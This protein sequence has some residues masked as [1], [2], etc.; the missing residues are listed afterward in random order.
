MKDSEKYDVNKAL[1]SGVF[2]GLDPAQPPVIVDPKGQ[3][4]DDPIETPNTASESAEYDP[5][6]AIVLGLARLTKTH[7][8]QIES[9]SGNKPV[10]RIVLGDDGGSFRTQLAQSL[11]AALL[12]HS[13]K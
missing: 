7:V 2:A 11:D 10:H 6:Y 1:V 4:I 3:R 8:V 9:G 5:M 13:P 12:H